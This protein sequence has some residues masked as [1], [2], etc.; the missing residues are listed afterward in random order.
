MALIDRAPLPSQLGLIAAVGSGVLL[1]G[2]YFFQYVMG[3]APC[4]MCLWQRWPHM[5]VIAA[6]LLA[7]L[8]YKTPRLAGMLLLVAIL[9]L[10]TTAAIGLFHAGV[11]LR[12]WQGPQACSGT[13]PTG[14][15]PE[16]LRKYLFSAKMVRCD[17]VAWSMLG[18]S[19]AG[20]NAILSA[21]LAI[22][23]AS[24]AARWVK[25]DAG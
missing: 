11:E 20:W 22:G 15:S 9:G 3:L 12:W 7:L 16:E 21:L 23:L 10:V 17:A 5:G 25:A 13:V 4:E 24:G 8:C 19:M 1:G 2:A 6:G 18:I 14:L